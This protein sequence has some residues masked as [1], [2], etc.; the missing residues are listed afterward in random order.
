MSELDYDATLQRADRPRER[1]E[2][3][4]GPASPMLALQR[5]AGN[6]AVT[7]GMDE[8]RSPIYDVIE[9]GRGQPLP[10]DTREQMEGTL[11]AD[12]GSV[13]VHTDH[14]AADSARSVNA[15]AYTV[16]ENVVFRP[17]RYEPDT[18]PGQQRLAHELTHVVQQRNGPVDG[19]PA[20]GGIKVSDPGDRF[21]QEA[22][23]NA[24][25]FAEGRSGE[26]ATAASASGATSVQRQGEGEGEEEE[27]AQMLSAQRQGEGEEE[28]TA[29]MLSAQR[30]GEG[31]EE[32]EAPAE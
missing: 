10:A 31:E 19:T 22:T 9:R 17:E 12:L 24:A 28:E 32:E 29:Q 1:S 25:A 3:R 2:R 4:E 18:L 15:D 5:L 11:G 30:Q 26:V 20:N 16:G 23:R 6:E 21:E 27:T 14:A 7:R 13:R 8:E